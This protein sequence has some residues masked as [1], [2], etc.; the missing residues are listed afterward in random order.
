MFR[1]HVDRDRLAGDR[2]DRAGEYA[3]PPGLY[4]GRRRNDDRLLRGKPLAGRGRG[5]QEQHRREG[6]EE[7]Y[8]FHPSA[9]PHGLRE[10]GFLPTSLYQ[11]LARYQFWHGS[12]SGFRKSAQSAC[13]P[14]PRPSLF[15]IAVL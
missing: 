4:L 6:G 8:T 1:G 5:E 11:M 3:V 13:T 7:K 12:S 2:G 15:T 9:P 14:A 10:K